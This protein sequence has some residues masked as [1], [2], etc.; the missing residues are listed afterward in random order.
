MIYCEIVEVK[1]TIKKIWF[2]LGKF[3]VLGH[4]F[5][6]SVNLESKLSFNNAM[7]WI[8]QGV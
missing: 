3:L 6:T 1:E 8:D 2:L 4:F 5:D 7:N